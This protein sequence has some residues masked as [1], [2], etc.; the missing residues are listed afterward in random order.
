[1]KKF[2]R[3][4]QIPIFEETRLCLALVSLLKA[5]IILHFIDNFE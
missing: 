1:M 2:V 3:C 5:N 4:R